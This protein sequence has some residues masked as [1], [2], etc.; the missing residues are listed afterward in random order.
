M[1]VKLTKKLGV[2]NVHNLVM[3][4]EEE[5]LP[6]QSLW[7]RIKSGL[8]QLVNLKPHIACTSMLFLPMK[9]VNGIVSQTND[10]VMT[11][12]RFPYN[13]IFVRGHYRPAV[14]FL[15]NCKWCGAL[16]ISVLLT[17]K[18]WW[19]S[20]RVVGDIKRSWRPCDVSIMS[21]ERSRYNTVDLSKVSLELTFPLIAR[22]CIG[23][24][25]HTVL[26]CVKFQNKMMSSNGNISA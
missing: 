22:C 24:A 18:S 6:W 13:W 8:W 17:W 5:L 23:H 26:F 21:L 1:P 16:G 7:L 9:W 25:S 2:T 10:D 3:R 4:I 20:D 11:W 14:D 15:T 12:K 19:T